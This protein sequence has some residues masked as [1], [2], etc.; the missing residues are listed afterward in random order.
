MKT[1]IIVL[2][3]VSFTESTIL[4]ID[5]VLI[6]LIARSYIRSDKSNLWL[7]FSFGLLSS[8]LNLTALGIQSLIYLTLVAVSEGLSKSRLAGNSFLIIPLSFVLLSLN[9]LIF[10]SFLSE[11]FLFPKIVLE[12]IFSLPILYLIRLWEERFIV[13]KEIKLRV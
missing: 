6:I 8:N 2:I 5:L 13:Q 3:I 4:P 1:L 12:A 10:A 7:A 11:S 9:Q